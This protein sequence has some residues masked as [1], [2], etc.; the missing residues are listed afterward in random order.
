MKKVLLAGAGG[1]IGTEF[2]RTLL[3]EEREIIA[4]DRFFFGDTLDEYKN[5]K[6]LKIVKDDIRY[7]DKKILKGVD[8]VINLA[9]ISN[10][11]ASE[12][13]PQITQEI[14]YEGALRLAAIAKEMKVK[15]YLFASS[16]SVYGAEDG[17]VSE[18]SPVYPISEYAKSKRKAEEQ[19]LKL[20]D[21]TFCVT[22]FRTATVYGISRKRMRFDIIINIMTLHAWKNNKIYIRGEGTQWRPLIHVTD[23][24]QGFMLVM[25]E[26]DK[27]KINKQIFNLGSNEQNYQV[28]QV[29]AKFK[30]YFPDLVIESVPDDPDNRSY[31]VNFDKISQTLRFKAKKTIDDGITEIKNA[32]EKGEISDAG[33]ATHTLRHYQYLIEADKILS[34]VKLDNK[35]F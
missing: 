23:C 7:V 22:V 1:Y 12:L 4:L 34:G 2:V 24:I 30:K 13:N 32:L 19:I 35:L 9:S 18:E 3:K 33:T 25:N 26:K 21:D 15:K 16:C 29:A 5:F 17:I 8:T 27:T 11:P 20:A 6:N 31:H 10:D 14:N 28:F